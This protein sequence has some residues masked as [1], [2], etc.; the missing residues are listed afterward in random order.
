MNFGEIQIM[1]VCR[2]IMAKPI[3]EAMASIHCFVIK[4]EKN[5]KIIKKFFSKYLNC[6]LIYGIIK[7]F[8]KANKK[9]EET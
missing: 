5:T 6:I 8:Y 4:C 1:M 7:E 3:Y 2:Q 9:S